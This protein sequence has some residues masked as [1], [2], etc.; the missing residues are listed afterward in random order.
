MNLKPTEAPE[1]I[2][3]KGYT[4]SDLMETDDTGYGFEDEAIYT[5]EVS[6]RFE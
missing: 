2:V 1:I 6:V 3:P 5:E 4:L